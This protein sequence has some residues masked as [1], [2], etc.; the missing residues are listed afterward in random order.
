MRSPLVPIDSSPQAW[1]ARCLALGEWE[2]A[3]V[4]EWHRVNMPPPLLRPRADEPVAPDV[5]D[6]GLRQRGRVAV[7]GPV[8]GSAA[9]R[10]MHPAEV[11]VTLVKR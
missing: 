3:S 2:A 5:V 1:R 9:K 4:R 8:P 7:A 10:A 6:N 11:P